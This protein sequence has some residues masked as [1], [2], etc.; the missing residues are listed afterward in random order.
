MLALELLKVL[1]ENSGPAFRCS[2]RFTGAIKQYLCLSL[3]KNAASPHAAAQALACSIFYT[4]LAKFR[5]ALKAEVGV[6]FPMILLRPIEPAAA[7]TT[8]PPSGARPKP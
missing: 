3:L 5:P 7:N 1:L 4:L 2:E 8:P 6:F